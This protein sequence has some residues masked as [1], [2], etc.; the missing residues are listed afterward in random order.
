[1]KV[2]GE[3]KKEKRKRKEVGLWIEQSFLLEVLRS[4]GL[5]SGV[6]LKP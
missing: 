6:V 2:G 1:M 3:K 5:F 4:K